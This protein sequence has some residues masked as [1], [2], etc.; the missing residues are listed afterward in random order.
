[1]SKETTSK[2]AITCACGMIVAFP[3]QHWRHCTFN[4]DNLGKTSVGQRLL[5]SLQAKFSKSE[6]ATI[7]SHGPVR[8]EKLTNRRR[9]KAKR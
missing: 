3:E 8:D 1:M 6:L 9:G 7:A 4:P 2:E 5:N